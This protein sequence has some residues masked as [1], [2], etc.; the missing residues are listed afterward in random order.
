MKVR[1][2]EHVSTEIV[3]AVRAMALN[4]GWELTSVVEVGDRSSQDVHWITKFASEGGH[5]IISGDTDFLKRPHQ[6]LAVNRTGMRVIHMPAKWSS[7]R[8]DLQAAFVL[9]WWRRIERTI[10]TMKQRECYRPP[11]NAT[12]DGDLAKIKVDYQDADKWERRQA[13]RDAQAA[14]QKGKSDGQPEQPA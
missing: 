5:A 4:P 11:W 7:A 12:E 10:S 2:D 3:R 6:V 1:A 13:K 9:L 14:A 8:C